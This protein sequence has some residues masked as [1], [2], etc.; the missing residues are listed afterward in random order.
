MS[1]D[2]AVFCPGPIQG[3]LVRPLKRFADSRGWLMELYRTDELPAETQPVMAYV[4]QTEPGGVRGPHEHRRQSDVF[5]F[6]GPGE[7]KL[8]L[9]DARR[10]SPTYGHRQTLIAGESDQVQVVVPPGVVHAYKNV[11]STPGLV[12]NCPDRLYAGAGR[13]EAVDE[14]RH[15]DLPESPFLLD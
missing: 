1:N 6:I 3:V 2:A 15:E 12:F 5:A 13:K 11:G 14:I 10:D 9:W 4:S 8:Y 7:F